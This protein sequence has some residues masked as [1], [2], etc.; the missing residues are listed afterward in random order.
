[1]HQR[2]KFIALVTVGAAIFT[3]GFLPSVSQAASSNNGQMDG[4]YAD[5]HG[6]TATDVR[7]INALNAR[8]L[9]LGQPPN[10]S[11]SFRAPA[12]SGGREIPPAEP[13]N[14]MPDAYRA[15]NG[16]ASTVVNNYIR[17]WQQVFSHRDGRAQQMTE[18]QR[19]KLSYGCVG[20]T[21]VNTG[22]YPTN[23][24][25]FSFFDENKY[26]NDLRNTSPRPNETRAEFE[27]RIAKGSFD[28]GK[29]FKRARGVASMMNKALENAHDEGT[30]INNLK[31]QL[32]NND[33]ALLRENS[34]SNFYSA[35]RNTPSFKE[36]D[37]G[38]YDPSKMKAVIYSKHFWSGQDSRSSS[39]MRKYGDP[40]AFRPD[41]ATGLVDMSRD[42]NISRSPSKPGESWV[43]FDYGWFG[44]QT[45][46]DADKTVWTHGNHYHAPNSD[47]G[48][49]H[50][51]ESNF[52]NWSSGYEDFDRGTYVITFVPKS[53]NTAPAKVTQG[54]Q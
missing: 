38:N 3:A 19:D 36:R 51:Y 47:M 33:D 32:A 31:T 39:D 5:T 17:K 14:R 22:P 9:T 13:L 12:P 27:G 30:Y 18:E 35:L 40:N 7:N 29:G 42:W 24:L 6:L 11:S 10:A 49:M 15:Y 37:G 8:A 28:E 46:A 21:W 34:S 20:V 52:R 25:A 44:A 41:Q 1:M 16:R 54:W 53:W 48:P 50:V 2:R 4:S 43:N 26:K 23:K 45:E